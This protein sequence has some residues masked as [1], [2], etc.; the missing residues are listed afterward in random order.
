MKDHHTTIIPYISYSHAQSNRIP[1]VVYNLQYKTRAPEKCTHI[2]F[3][4]SRIDDDT[5][6]HPSP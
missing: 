5:R 2:V 4:V 1:R 6:P 3:I